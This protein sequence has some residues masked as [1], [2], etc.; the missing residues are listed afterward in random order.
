M[1]KFFYA[2]FLKLLTI[3]A[4]MFA[5]IV[6]S[7]GL[8][9]DAAILSLE[10]TASWYYENSP[11]IK[12]TTAN[13]EIFDHDK[14]TCA[15]WDFAFDTMLEVTNVQNGRKVLVRVNDRGPAKRLYRQGRIVDLTKAA[16]QKIEDL[17]KGLA[18]VKIRIIK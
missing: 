9:S 18:S 1:K 7:I 5:F 10:G 14:L 15:S 6:I 3:T 8:S 16:F 17:D 4:T 11:G 2:H 12:P 13:M